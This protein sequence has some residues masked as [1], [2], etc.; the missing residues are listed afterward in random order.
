[1]YEGLIQINKKDINASNTC[2]SKEYGLMV[3]TQKR[4]TND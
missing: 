2:M 1:M 4:D 3:Y